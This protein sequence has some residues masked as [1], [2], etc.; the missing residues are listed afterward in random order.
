[1]YARRRASN[2]TMVKVDQTRRQGLGNCIAFISRYR[3]CW[4]SGRTSGYRVSGRSPN[5]LA[6][7]SAR[8][9]SNANATPRRPSWDIVLS[10]LS[11]RSHARSRRAFFLF[12][13]LRSFPLALLVSSFFW[14]S[15][16]LFP[17][18]FDTLTPGK[19][20]R[21]IPDI[22]AFPDP[23]ASSI[24]PGNSSPWSFVANTGEIE[25]RE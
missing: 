4:E 12:Q 17:F 13:A 21:D 22:F 20:S 14:F 24:L 11:S 5:W 7:P 10:C 1:M 8:R 6:S 9:I 23:T 19:E 16:F 3:Y 25:E 18:L 2:S 15:R